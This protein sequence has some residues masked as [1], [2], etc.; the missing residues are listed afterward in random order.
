MMT[1]WQQISQE[2]LKIALKIVFTDDLFL[3]FNPELSGFG[4]IFS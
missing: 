3:S 4:I 2:F 1:K